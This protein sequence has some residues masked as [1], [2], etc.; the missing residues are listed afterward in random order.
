MNKILSAYF[1]S[2]LMETGLFAIAVALSIYYGWTAKDLLWSLWISSL[3]IGYCTILFGIG[4]NFIQGKVADDAGPD[5][6]GATSNPDKKKLRNPGAVMA[7]F[8]LLPI[9]GIFG[10]SIITLIYGLFAGLSIGLAVV[11]Y[12]SGDPESEAVRFLMNFIINLPSTAFILCFFT[13]HFGG[14]H[15]VHSIFLNGFFPLTGDTP[16]GKSIEG[17]CGMFLTFISVSVISYWPFIV[18]S[19]AASLGDIR[20]TVT[21]KK[22]DIFLNPYKNVIK[23]HLMIFI[24]AFM[25]AG[26]LKPYILYAALVVYFF[27]FS[28]LFRFKKKTQELT[29]GS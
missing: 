1:S 15:F 16:F 29:E 9:A 14:F 5:T 3:T 4:R 10:F 6:N 13:I 26:G 2:F 7:V 18:T 24:I 8:F 25:G 28:K 22:G 21:G 17:T 12:R 11:R 27:P 20:N 19:A 23:M